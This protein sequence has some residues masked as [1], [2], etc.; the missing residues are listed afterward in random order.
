MGQAYVELGQYDE[1]IASLKR[2]NDID[3]ECT[4]LKTILETQPTPGIL[5]IALLL[6]RETGC[7]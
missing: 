5:V 6:K 3:M 2:G 7:I 4:F 1:A